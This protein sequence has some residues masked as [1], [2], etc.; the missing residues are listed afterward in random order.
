MMMLISILREAA[1]KKKYLIGGNCEKGKI[2]LTFKTLFL[3]SKGDG[4]KVFA[5]F[6]ASH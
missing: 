4:D 3:S 2:I 1:R 6:E 5:P